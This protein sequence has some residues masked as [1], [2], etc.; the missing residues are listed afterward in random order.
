M[1]HAFST[2]QPHPFFRN[3]RTM[4]VPLRY[5]FHGLSIPELIDIA[6]HLPGFQE[7]RQRWIASNP[8][9]IPLNNPTYPN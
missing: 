8:Q 2:L 7:D 5:P 9:H 1:C 6:S 4:E 3:I